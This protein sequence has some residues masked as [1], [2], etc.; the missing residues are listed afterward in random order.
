VLRPAHWNVIKH[1][2]FQFRFAKLQ[3][4]RGPVALVRRFARGGR[5]GSAPGNLKEGEKEVD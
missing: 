2:A 4:D 5:A 3:L 1:H